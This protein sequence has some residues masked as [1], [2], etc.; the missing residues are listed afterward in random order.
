MADCERADA[1]R[2]C[3]TDG[4]EDVLDLGRHRLAGQFPGPGEPDPPSYPLVLCQCPGCNL[5]QLRHTVDPELQFRSYYYRSGISATMHQHLRN[6]AGEAWGLTADDPLAARKVLD[7]GC[8]DGTLLAHTPACARGRYGIDP[9]D[10]ECPPTVNRVRGFFPAALPKEWPSFDLV[11]TVACLY[12]ADDPVKFASAVRDCLTPEGIWCVE[13]ADLA[14]MIANLSYDSILHEHLCY[15]DLPSLA[16][17]LDLA[18]MRAVSSSVNDSNGGSLRVYGRRGQGV[19][20]PG[21]DYNLVGFASQVR[22]HRRELLRYLVG[23]SRA[24]KRVHLLG[25][26][27]KANTVLQF[28]DVDPGLVE[29]ASDRDPR[30][31]GRRCPGTNIPILT[32]KDSRALEPDVYLTVLGH[33]RDELILR[34]RS[35]GFRGEIAFAL[36][37]LEVVQA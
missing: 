24:G 27:S 34:E 18:G 35:A 4:L 19:P 20:P 21:L 37:R 28:A 33:F 30:K 16:F 15:Y 1:C 25:A 7:V 10:V 31:A 9:A 36:P 11:Y 8:N 2:L 5:V 3:G 17:C 14:A 22:Q 13:V 23:C 26:S 29:Y 12:D 32:E 6:L